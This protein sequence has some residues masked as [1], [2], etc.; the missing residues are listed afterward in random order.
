MKF[1]ASDLK[2]VEITSTGKSAPADNFSCTA[3]KGQ[4][5]KVGFRSAPPGGE[6]DGELLRISLF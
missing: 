3:W 1:H 4:K 2:T 5:A 6:Y